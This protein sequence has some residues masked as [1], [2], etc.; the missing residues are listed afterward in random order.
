VRE[1]ESLLGG[2][3]KGGRE[4]GGEKKA[5]EGKTRGGETTVEVCP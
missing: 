2:L 4:G 5:I 1:T 3:E